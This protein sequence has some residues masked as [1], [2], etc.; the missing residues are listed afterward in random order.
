MPTLQTTL[1][2]DKAKWKGIVIKDGSHLRSL[3]T[4]A[5]AEIRTALK[6]KAVASFLFGSFRI[7]CICR[8]KVWA[9]HVRVQSRYPNWSSSGPRKDSFVIKVRRVC[10][11]LVHF[12]L[13]WPVFL[14]SGHQPGKELLPEFNIPKWW[15]PRQVL[16]LSPV[17]DWKIIMHWRYN[18]EYCKN[19]RWT[20]WK[21]EVILFHIFFPQ[22]I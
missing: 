2:S 12:V 1:R 20:F 19:V 8:W 11:Y 21:A 16:H 17:D 6:R 10:Y 9:K 3:P 22:E 5:V 13:H 15:Y 4:V 18:Y 7:K 14:L